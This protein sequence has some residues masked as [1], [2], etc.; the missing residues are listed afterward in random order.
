MQEELREAAGANSHLA[1]KRARYG[2]DVVSGLLPHQRM[3]DVQALCDPPALNLMAVLV[4]FAASHF[5]SAVALLDL[6][7][8]RSQGQHACRGG[9]PGASASSD[10]LGARGLMLVEAL[11]ASCGTHELPPFDDLMTSKTNRASEPTAQQLFWAPQPLRQLLRSCVGGAPHGGQ[12]WKRLPSRMESVA[13]T[14]ATTSATTHVAAAAASNRAGANGTAVATPQ[15]SP[16]VASPAVM[17]P[18]A[19]MPSPAG[20]SLPGDGGGP[21]HIHGGRSGAGVL[22]SESPAGA[23]NSRS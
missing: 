21:H 10:I 22:P 4:S 11:D 14:A 6:V 13:H 16:P 7:S 3:K 8:Y 2:P 1:R 5:G 15:A 19:T 20:V 9:G 12:P 23:G 17:S 18:A